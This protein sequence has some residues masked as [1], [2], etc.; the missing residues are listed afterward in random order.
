MLNALIV[1][2]VVLAAVQVWMAVTFLRMVNMARTEVKALG[3]RLDA[4][5]KR[6]AAYDGAL[7]ELRAKTGH[8]HDSLVDTLEI[9][10]GWRPNNTVPTLV[11][12]GARV[13]RS[14]S[15]QRRAKQLP[16]RSREEVK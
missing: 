2:V 7:S 10:G 15:T 9:L 4:L 12:L 8:Q 3:K 6:C 13:F 5:D 14:Y 1:L 16:V 11:A